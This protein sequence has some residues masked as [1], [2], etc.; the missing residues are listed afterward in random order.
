MQTSGI[1][2]TTGYAL[3]TKTPTNTNIPPQPRLSTHYAASGLLPRQLVGYETLAGSAI[4]FIN[5]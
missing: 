3:D 5:N 2:T 1:I 4:T